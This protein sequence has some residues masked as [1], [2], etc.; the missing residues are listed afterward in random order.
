VADVLLVDDDSQVVD[1]FALALRLDGHRVRPVCD[2]WTAL[3]ESASQAPDVAVIDVGLPRVN[4]IDL[5]H[6]LRHMHGNAVG[7]IGCTGGYADESLHWNRARIVFDRLFA[8]PVRIEALL[9]AVRVLDRTRIRSRD[10]QPA[11]GSSNGDAAER[12]RR[13][14]ADG[15][16]RLKEQR[17]RIE[18]LLRRGY[19]TSEAR[20]LLANMAQA[21][22]AM[23][24]HLALIERGAGHRP[25]ALAPKRPE[26]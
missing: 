3:F 7:V 2:G 25:F 23:R 26:R 13:H 17:A 20:K 19:D 6:G 11:S 21:Q 8:K 4:G 10:A 24:G 14:V 16:R 22:L 9:D 1:T 18:R 15:E 12:A 5:A